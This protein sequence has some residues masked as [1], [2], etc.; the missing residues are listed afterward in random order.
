MRPNRRPYGAGRLPPPEAHRINH[1]IVAPIV[2]VITDTGEQLGLLA[3]A[4]AIKL[5]EDRGLD[6][7]EVAPEAQ[8]PVCKMMDYGKFKYQEEKR[9]RD[10]RKN[11]T[12]TK[13]KELRMSYRTDVGDF[14]TIIRKGREFIEE[15]DKVKI[16]MRFRGREAMHIDLGVAKLDDV[17]ERFKD[18]AFVDERSPSRGNLIYLV[19]AP[20][21]SA[22]KKV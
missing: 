15:G 17:V 21:K 6:L 19:L 13:L 18:I 7:V 14:D 8:P 1:R 4:V 16:S 3:P 5:A 11:R 20:G 2:R 9:E 10:S 22:P 12:E